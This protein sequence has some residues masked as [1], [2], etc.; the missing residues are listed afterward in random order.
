MRIQRKDF[1]GI[2]DNDWYYYCSKVIDGKSSETTYIETAIRSN[3]ITDITI[4][5]AIRDL[6][7]LEFL[8]FYNNKYFKFLYSTF[9]LNIFY[10]SDSFNGEFCIIHIPKDIFLPEEADMLTSILRKSSNDFGLVIRRLDTYTL[11]SEW[12]KQYITDECYEFTQETYKAFSNKFPIERKSNYT[13]V[14]QIKNE[15]EDRLICLIRAQILNNQVRFGSTNIGERSYEI[16][17]LIDLLLSEFIFSP[18]MYI[19]VAEIYYRYGL[20]QQSHRILNSALEFSQ[21]DNNIKSKIE[22]LQQL[23]KSKKTK[24]KFLTI[25]EF[26]GHYFEDTMHKHMTDEISER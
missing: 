1:K 26:T 4:L 25:E 13:Q 8:D 2:F 3:Y 15:I 11:A 19:F 7:P 16:S 21:T 9:S 24:D 18:K 6:C 14:K 10:H 20:P 12:K 17:E 22:R 23:I 5:H